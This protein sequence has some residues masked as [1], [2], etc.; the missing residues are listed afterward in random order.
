MPDNQ[1]VERT[2][3]SAGVEHSVDDGP[4]READ[5]YY[6]WAHLLQENES[7]EG[8]I[9][10]SGREKGVFFCIEHSGF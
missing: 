1:Y 10:G 9:G 5:K 6:F 4:Q 8:V 2:C 7:Q 3:S